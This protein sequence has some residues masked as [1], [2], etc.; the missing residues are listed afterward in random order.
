MNFGVSTACFY[1]MDLEKTIILLGENNVKNIEIFFNTYSDLS[2]EFINRVIN[3]TVQYDI[4]VV[5]AHPFTCSFEPFM[6]FTNY[7]RRFEDS[8]EMQKPYFEAMQK[9]NAKIYV[10]HGD[11]RESPMPNEQYFERFSRLCDTAKPFGITV[12][13]EN[14]ERCKSGSLDFLCEMVNYLDDVSIVFDNKQCF[15]SGI[16]QETFIEKLGKNIIHVHISDND[17]NSDCLA[18]SKGN[19]DF[20]NLLNQ[21][22]NKGFNKNVIVELY[23]NKIDSLNEIYD[24]YKKLISIKTM[25]I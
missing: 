3:L 6:M 18:I 8:L 19:L 25:Q 4:N 20:S 5:S 15:R 10:F 21:L 11:R 12:A 9:L 1:P 17:E 22:E 13:Q 23:S 14:V 2:S 16:K 7:E 24:S